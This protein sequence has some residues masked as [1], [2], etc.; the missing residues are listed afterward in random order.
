MNSCSTSI[1][2]PPSDSR[3]YIEMNFIKT[4]VYLIARNRSFGAITNYAKEP[5]R[6][7]GCINALLQCIGCSVVLKNCSYFKIEK[8]Q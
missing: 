3:I 2:T 8:T 5:S 1:I 6:W 7:K 4:D